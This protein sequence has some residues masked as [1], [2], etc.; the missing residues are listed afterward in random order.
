MRLNDCKQGAR[1]R[2]LGVHTAEA[3][4]ARLKA[5]G[6]SVGEEVTVLRVSPRKRVWLVETAFATFALGAEIAAEV[7]VTA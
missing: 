4:S 1:A 6:L 2:V 7:E 3:L 5:L